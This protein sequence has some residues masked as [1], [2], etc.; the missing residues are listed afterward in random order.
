[1]YLEPTNSSPGD[2]PGVGSSVSGSTR[3]TRRM[4]RMGPALPERRC[5]WMGVL[6][7]PPQAS[8]AP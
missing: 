4:G 3:S 7:I 8:V 5:S 2:P 6:A 1:M